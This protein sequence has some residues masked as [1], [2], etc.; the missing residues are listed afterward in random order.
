MDLVQT[1]EFHSGLSA[2]SAVL[3]AD[4]LGHDASAAPVV[5][6]DG[7]HRNTITAIVKAADGPI[8]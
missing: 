7:K 4:V 6:R 5:N 3:P 8:I 2:F 1:G